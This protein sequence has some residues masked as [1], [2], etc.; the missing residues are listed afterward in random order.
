M[1]EKEKYLKMKIPEEEY[2]RA[3]IEAWFIAI[4]NKN[5]LERR[6]RFKD[7]SIQKALANFF[8]SFSNFLDLT[9]PLLKNKDI[10]N[11]AIKFRSDFYNKPNGITI[12]TIREVFRR[13]A[14]QCKIDGLIGEEAIMLEEGF[15]GE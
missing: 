12:K 5:R 10:I 6:F 9:Q 3:I 7:G 13:Y 4:M 14:L 15:V 2:K 11:E 1:P 8:E